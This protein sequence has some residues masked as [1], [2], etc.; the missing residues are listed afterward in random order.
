MAYLYTRKQIQDALRE[1][2]IKPVDGKVTTRE[3]ARILSWRAMHE[4]RIEHI[5]PE[6]AVRRHVQQ[7]NLKVAEQPNIRFNLY[8]AEDVFALPMV[9]KRGIAQQKIAE[10]A[11]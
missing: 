6:S 5:Y 8:I 3:A 10:E 1:L 2:A 9:P 11:A 4:E 7:K